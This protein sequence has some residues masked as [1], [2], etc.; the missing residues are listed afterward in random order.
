LSEDQLQLTLGL[1]ESASCSITNDDIAP[2]LTVIKHVVNNDDGTAVAGDWTMDVTAGNPSSNNFAGTE[3]PGNTIT[4][5]AGAY[6]VDES[7]GPDGYAKTL[8]SGCS[9]NLGVG[10]SASCTITNND[11]PPPPTDVPIPTSGNWA[12][13][14]LILMLLATGWYFR[15]AVMRRF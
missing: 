5:D 4:V 2:Q 9:G 10:G 14:L 8:G 12:K 6:S 7:G 3:A 1:G 13:V 11:I 15:P